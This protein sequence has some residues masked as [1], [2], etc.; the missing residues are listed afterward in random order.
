MGEY[1]DYLA[2]LDTDPGDG[3]ALSGLVQLGASLAT[4][5]VSA[6]LDR[7]RDDLRERGEHELVARLFDVEIEHVSDD[8]RRAELLRQQAHLYVDDLLD[9]AA[10][11]ACFEKLLALR[12]EDEDATETLEQLALVRENWSK[13]VEKYVAEAE[14]ATD[15][16]LATSMYV[17]AAE[18][19]ARHEPDGGDVERHLR[20][21]LEVDPQNRRAANHLARLLRRGE[22][23]KELR[24]LL[25]E[26]VDLA[27]SAGERVQALLGLADVAGE[28]LDL[29]ELALDSMKKVIA[30][31]PA[32]P[33]ALA[34]LREHYEAEENWAQ[35]VVLYEGA[36]KS[37]RRAAAPETE[38]GML[39]Q[40]GM[41]HWKQL[42]DPDAAEG[43][44]ARLRKLD[45][46]HPAALDFY[47]AYYTDRGQANKLTQ[48]YRQALKSAPDEARRR[49]LRIE[50][51]ELSEESL[52]SPEKAIDSWKAIL[53]ADPD[54]EAARAALKRLYARTEK[55]NAL[56]DLMK[57]EVE[58]L[59]SEDVEARVA[60]LFE[61]VA[62]YRDRLR[63]DVMVINTYNSI[64]AIDPDNERALDALGERYEALGRWNDLIA[65]L[66]RQAQRASDPGA[67]ADILRRIAG[68]WIDRFGNYA[69][70]I[71]PLEE[72]L[73][74]RPGDA[75]AVARLKDIYTR[76]RQW[77]ALIG[78]MGH[79]AAQLPLDERR[80]RF[81]EMARLAGERLGDSRLA[82]EIWNR[83]LELP[84][85][86]A[87]P[88]RTAPDTPAVFDALAQLYDRDKRY[89]ALAE[90]HR[91]QRRLAIT[92]E[93]AIPVLE[94]LGALLA[95]RLDAPAQ[96]AEVY[97]E[98]LELDPG[99]G[100]AA[101]TLRELY[102][103]SGDYDA[104][105]A[106]YSGLGQWDDLVEALL[107]IAERADDR[108]QRKALL[109]R[110]AEIA[111]EHLESAEK[112][113][114]VYERLQSVEPGHLGAARALV[115]LYERIGKWGRLLATY[116]ILVDSAEDADKAALYDD[117][118]ALCEQR[119]GSKAQ[120]FQWTA[121]AY[122]LRPDDAELL[123]DLER[124][125][126]EAD[127]WDEVSAIL[128]ERASSEDIGDDERLR[129]LRE[130][131]TIAAVRLHQPER[132]QGYQRRVL[133]LRPDDPQALAALEELATQKAEWPQLLEIYRRR[134]EL[135]EDREARLAL[136]FKIAF[137]EE[138]RLR[139]A[140]AATATYRRVLDIDP[141]SR[142]ALK[143][144]VKIAEAREDW[145]A[146]ADALERELA[147]ESDP[148]A[149][150]ALH[151]RLGGLYEAELG[152]QNDALAGY[153]AAL[154]LGPSSQIHAA[155]ERFLAGD[156]AA[157]VRTEVAELLLP[158][159]EQADEPA[160]IARALEIL[161]AAADP[162]QALVRDRRLVELYAE[163]LGE[164]ARAFDTAARVLAADAEDVANRE[165]LA[166]LASALDREAELA[167]RLEEAYARSSDAGAEPAVLLGLAEAVAALRERTGD[168]GAAAAWRR[169]LE[170]DPTQARA[171]E[172]V[173]RRLRD[174]GQWSE[175][176]ELLERR[177]E[178]TLDATERAL[179]LADIATLCET[180]L[181]DP[182]AA[183]RA[184]ERLLE[185][186]PGDPSAA[187]ALDRLYTA[188]G[189][190]SD[191]EEL[192]GRR[193]EHVADERAADALAM[194]RAR[195][196]LEH[197][198]DT[199]GAI[200]LAE[201][202]AGRASPDP[203][204]RELLES[205]LGDRGH[206][207]RIARLLEQ[208][209]E[210]A[211]AFEPLTRV[212]RVQ[213]GE[214]ESV[215]EA[216]ALLARVAAL[217]EDELADAAGAFDAWL[218]ALDA[219][220][221][222]ERARA[223]ILRLGA[224]LD[225]WPDVAAALETAATRID[226]T[227]VATR[228]ELQAAAAAVVDERLGDP[229]RA[230]AA[231]QALLDTDPTDP[232]TVRRAAA[233]LDRLH[234]QAGRYAE[235]ITAL[236]RRAEWADSAEERRDLLGRVAGIEE[237]ELGDPDAAAATWREVL[238]E[239]P[240]AAPALDALERLLAA[241][242][243]SR[244]LV[245]ILR[246]RVELAHEPEERRRQLLRLAA[247]HE[248]ELD[249]PHEAVTTLLEVLDV[250]PDDDATL[251]ELAR[252]YRLQ[253]RP[254]DLL[255]VLERR[256][257]L[258]GD[259]GRRVDLSL[260]AAA[261]L[262]TELAR[263]SEALERYAEILGAQ[264]MHP[265]ARARV[266]A[267][268]GEPDLR[269]RAARILLP[270][271]E[272]Q[273]LHAEL[274]S[275]LELLADTSDDPRATIDHLRR[276][277]ALREHQ[278][279]DAAGAFEAT[280][281]A[282]I[283]A[284]AEPE[285]PGIL[286]ELQR[287]A[288]DQG[289]LG[290]LI[291]VYA[292]VAPEVFDGDLQRRL[293]LDIA[294]LTRAVRQD[295]AAARDY[296][297]KVL[298]AQPDDTRA[299]A[300]LEGLYRD[301]GDSA[302]LHEVLSRKA[303]L[304]GEDL[305]QRA[306]ALFEAA[307]LCAGELGRAED[308]VVLW[309]QVLEL[310]PENTDAAAALERLYTDGE[311]WHDLTDLLER[312]LGFAF[313]VEEA[314]DLRFRLG[315]IYEQRLAD[316]DSAVESYGAALGGDPGHA[317]ATAAL[318]RLLDDP[319]TR[320]A[321]AEVLEPIYVSHQDWPRLVRIYEIKLEAA[322]DPAERLQLT[323]YIARLYEDQ[324]EDLDGAFRWYGRVFRESPSDRSVRAQLVR[325]AS[326]LDGWGEL[327][328][329]YQEYLDDETSDAPEVREVATALAE[330]Y[331]RRTG[332]VERAHAA[333]R[334]VLQ[335]DPDDDATFARL[336]EML[337]RAERWY[338]LVAAYEEVVHASV[339]DERR[340]DIYLRLAKVQELRLG[341][342][343]KGIDALRAVLEVSP[344]HPIAIAE[345][346]RLLQEQKS[347]HDLSDL[348]LQQLERAEGEAQLLEL[349]MRLAQLRE[350]RLEDTEGAIEQ[351]EI[352]LD[353]PGGDIALPALERLVVDDRHRERI[354]SILE[355]VYREHDWWQKL[356][357]ILDAQLEYV[358]DPLRRGE[359]LREIARIH[360]SRGGDLHLALDALGKAWLEEVGDREVY[361]DF[362]ALG[363]RLG[364]WDRLVAVLE[365]GVREHFD[366]D[367]VAMVLLEAA[368]IHEVER[369]DRE[370]AIAVLRRL[371]DSTDD[372]PETLAELDRLLE[373]GEHWDE[374]VPVIERRAELSVDPSERL[375]LL[376]R[377]AL[378]AEKQLPD[379]GVAIEKW[380]S[381]LAADDV[382]LDALE[383][384]E[385]LHREEG[386]FAEASQMLVRQIE[387]AEDAEERR[388]LRLAAATLF[389]DQLG[390][391]FE[392]VA[393][394]VALRDDQPDD[395]EALARLDR[396]YLAD[397]MWPELLEVLE[398]RAELATDA[399]ERAELTFRAAR[400]VELELAE[401]ERAI[402]GYARVLDIEPSYQGARAALD[403][404]AR[405]EL[406]LA[407]ATEVLERVYR[408]DG[409]HDLL[410]GLYELRLGAEIADP[411]E[412]RGLYATLA[413]IRELQR[414]DVDAAFA[415]WGRALAE[416]PEDEA[417][418]GHLERL[419]GARGA[420]AELA[421]LLEARLADIVDSELEHRYARKLAE[422]YE[423]ALGD[424][425]RAALSLRR[426]LDV[427]DDEA[428]VL[429]GLSRI[430][431]RAE[432]ADELAEVLAR[433]AEVVLDE[434]QQADFLFRLGDVR[435]QRQ[436]DVSGAVSAYRDVL[437]R[438]PGHAAARS[439]L[440]RILAS[441]DDE[442]ADVIATLEPLYEGEGEWA[443][444]ADLLRT[445]LMVT[446][447][448]FDRAQ[449]YARI[450]ELAEAKLADPVSALDAA[451]GWL[452]E[453]PHSEEALAELS[454]LGEL[455]GRW[456]E[457]A[458]RLSGIAST[459]DAGEVRLRLLVRLGAVQERELGDLAAAEQS[460]RSALEIDPEAAAAL[461]ALER[462]HR[463]QGNGAA[464][465]EVLA[466]RGELAFDVTVK[467]D[468]YAEVGRLREELGDADAAL[469]AWRQ[470]LELDEADREAHAHLAALHE[471][472]G[473]WEELIDVLGIASR[474]ATDVAE[475]R[476]LRT[477][478]ARIL[479]ETLEELDR[480]IDAWQSV[481]DLEPTAPDAFDAL[482]ALHRRRE[483][484]L[485]V[486]EIL[487]RRLDVTDDVAARVAIA[488]R[489]AQVAEVEREA[490]EE[491]IDVLHRILELD[492]GHEPTYANLERL[493]QK[494]ER[495]HDL[496]ELFER[497]AELTAS[498]GDA[499]QEI[500]WLAQAADVWEG[501]LDNPDAAGEILEKILARDPSFVP[502][503]TRLAKI[504]EGASDWGRC[505]EVLE[506][507]LSL[508]PTGADAAELYV[509]LG[510]VAR[511]QSGDEAAA[512]AH[513]QQALVHDPTNAA[514]VRAVEA[515]ARERDD[516]PLVV[517]MLRRR[518]GTT[519]GAGERLEVLVELAE[520]YG[521]RLGQPEQVIPL[522]ESAAQDAP[523]DPRVLG[524][525]ADSYFHAG[526]HGE[527][528]PL[529]ERLAEDA[530][531]G[532]RMKEVA[533]YRQRLGGIFRA[534]GDAE[535]AR[536][537]YEEAFRVDPTNVDTMA[538][539]GQLYVEGQEWDKARRVYR[540]LV[541]QNIDPRA[542]LSKADV[543]YNLGHIHLQLGED[544]KAKGMFQRG[545]EIEPE[546]Q[547]L[548]QAL[549]SLA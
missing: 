208:L 291:D 509:R 490:P 215:A 324:L 206:R 359:M 84:G 309:E 513:F 137:I 9:E 14:A 57:E 173:E 158:A 530:K 415:T 411:D 390:D 428:E 127:A 20:R 281:R 249:D 367:L 83:L 285:L 363:S 106:L 153:R 504:Y 270:L 495:H 529:Y 78:L 245:E 302:N 74:L 301:A 21:A 248:R 420:W 406:T 232:E 97:R 54:D 171:Y 262:V 66:G 213:A 362:V 276:V 334:R 339:D 326:V 170:L 383:S 18:T 300:A 81:A 465:A 398:R 201:E 418:A 480:A 126:A 28:R 227:D 34:M 449:L 266:E 423:E 176:R 470:V 29:P 69:Q 304:A 364:A 183:I 522:L 240:D 315:R 391:R 234:G 463:Q 479:G 244:D 403:A 146:V 340:V 313:T 43:H 95:D 258:A 466:R 160:K 192:L 288:A 274:A 357:V 387:F 510:E 217:R 99:H 537:A 377:A 277:A 341:D 365:D 521:T 392:A 516:W 135:E 484:W 31:D 467:R 280:R 225:R 512:Q 397:S 328:N 190:W 310:T 331:D 325:L 409:A 540:S 400:L 458:A 350:K 236:R 45:P 136:L 91:R 544:A 241:A 452:A 437:D 542:G 218:E 314:V 388:H 330:I 453:D 336:E 73:E 425:D 117:I 502:A 37:R 489:M 316:P 187:D 123:A 255:D 471:Q 386:Q 189:R 76:R 2:M 345:L 421:E 426:A 354:A 179:V 429:A 534:T 98:I 536:A 462:I 172:A 128:D 196:R 102:A 118:R 278:L 148:D 82:I 142:R 517:D 327:A 342:A 58:K 271:Y 100:R 134:V 231:Y 454:R 436:G 139:D 507:A 442:R 143:A 319:G 167:E 17:A 104:L 239:D 220:P 358:E 174:Q 519:E 41:L 61:V 222:D 223:A 389:E 543:Y 282:L 242:G 344:D 268:L 237:H 71:Q 52:G 111:S 535:R 332:E 361:G 181:E 103:A 119:L 511:Q 407:A 496:V 441:H 413:E 230:A 265:E 39:I 438:A 455:A 261:L 296:Y 75:D 40:I 353:L 349:R 238:A 368:R 395:A 380:Q 352:A 214:A 256:L 36:L 372:H 491:A 307:E 259:E 337:T 125:G 175:L 254:G 26:R 384:L 59:P 12:P 7:A 447:D 6:A 131:G 298:D 457:V 460:Y 188:A 370:R 444:L 414:G 369:A 434:G 200:D 373:E 90:I 474:H 419:A 155:L 124:L 144:L 87:D 141:G 433:Q 499:R 374:V 472:R 161:R 293:Y 38:I 323:R 72:L 275:L 500:H 107:G 478:T 246:R 520:L 24:T 477:R 165:R 1:L 253:E 8:A 251:A 320:G 356:V 5:E 121:R 430:Y 505:S 226:P 109:E 199:A 229:E 379:R 166:E 194:R 55:W 13:L 456:S 446:E 289:R 177:G 306:A 424:L 93:A 525:L 487:T 169:V 47:R 113:A 435:E 86:E 263:P 49:A 65:V 399:S 527:A 376:K 351:Y 88:D 252:L 150:I 483:D 120:A 378:V 211:G 448:A 216:A 498:A 269:P 25:E 92:P 526:R 468:C 184:Y 408:A 260:E 114:R 63:L 292:E 476:A 422:L 115:P 50:L 44:F 531:R 185:L 138:D 267:F 15:K 329:V 538:G 272:E 205:L 195:L 133:E 221:A 404:L 33:R 212:L 524:P 547:T 396:L 528:A 311:R 3:R 294:D 132:A 473:A 68:L 164:P 482:E 488:T 338:A 443:R 445:K 410:A 514:A 497:R 94:K 235:Q 295:D 70:A 116:E 51:A 382:D 492:G 333:Y 64:L 46:A 48:V 385:R 210:Q 366:H 299:L 112:I 154:A 10:G 394:L 303:E 228:T 279:G 178:H 163:R 145:A 348:L 321:A 506:R 197:T 156:V 549:D 347:W 308:A 290:E 257:A 168:P 35:L 32:H 202:L 481:L 108:G 4:D 204:A 11:V 545:L 110:A 180:Q 405:S 23:W 287:L 209:Y 273:E 515:A 371:L 162:A 77:R 416:F 122:R 203:A 381:V 494:V 548:K 297:Q 546:H 60:G 523:D 450:A 224:S 539:L 485:A 157:E 30:V 439:A 27:T 508:G 475:D 85:S 305:D 360:E 312:R 375:L 417:I 101:R 147:I 67:R 469:G 440:E 22:R 461:E 284:L 80:A 130:L 412:R 286:A 89:L 140:D 451:G 250:A 335:A 62:I 149:Q 186:E 42:G 501:P 247:L 346:D 105:E 541:L 219:D 317:G 129:L 96:A 343:G 401:P 402:D 532:R 431:E 151:L 191:L 243:Q 322:D 233:A 56:L 432:R 393:H 533:R 486:Q 193:V 283:P 207:G 493:L 152:R 264:P 503:L 198:G 464:L 459:T 518:L 318:E 53:R 159:Y 79:E 355:P 182:E 16:Q 19:T 427:T